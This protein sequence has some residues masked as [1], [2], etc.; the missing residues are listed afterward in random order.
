MDQY[1]SACGKSGNAMLLDC[2]TLKCE[3]VPV[4]LGGYSL[5]IINCNKPHNL[6]ESR[7]NERRAETD[8]GLEA[9][10]D[11]AGITC[12]ADLTLKQFDR[13]ASLLHNKIRYRVKHVVEECER[14]KL[15]QNAMAAGDMVTLGRLLNESHT[16]LRYLYEVTGKELDALASAAQGHPA[17]AGSRMTGG[18]FG[19]CTISIVK[20]E[21][22]E[23]FKK[24]VLEKYEK[25]TG[26]KATCY[27]AEISDGITVQKL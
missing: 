18:G 8:A 27:E 4:K 7:Y 22:V 10:K 24:Y 12:L 11:I 19:G 6:V 26:Y 13:C 17:C 16:S 15:A 9:L 3:Y 2:K 5:V 21:A 20:T 23:D 14:V 1:A 25:A